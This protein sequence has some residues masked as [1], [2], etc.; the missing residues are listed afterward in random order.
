MVVVCVGGV[1]EEEFAAVKGNLDAAQA[2]D[3][4]DQILALSK[5]ERGVTELGDGTVRRVYIDTPLV[6]AKGQVVADWE[7]GQVRIEAQN[8]PSQTPAMKHSSSRSMR[9][10]IWGRCS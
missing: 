3:L 8:F 6:G 1:T 2:Q 10:R 5:K 4:E 9:R 7:K